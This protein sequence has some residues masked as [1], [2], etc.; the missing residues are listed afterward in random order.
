MM[1]KHLRMMENLDPL[2]FLRQKNSGSIIDSSVIIKLKG[3]K[4]LLII[5]A[6]AKLVM[7][8]TKT[9]R[10]RNMKNSHLFFCS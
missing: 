5:T 4:S 10:V 8:I 2:Q 1:K 7:I 3:L 9:S 6:V